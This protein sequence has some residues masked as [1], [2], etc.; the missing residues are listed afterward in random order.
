METQLKEKP[1]R[2]NQPRKST[3][4]KIKLVQRRTLTRNPIRMPHNQVTYLKGSSMDSFTLGL[5]P[6]IDFTRNSN[7]LRVSKFSQ[8]LPKHPL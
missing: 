3:I 4:Q 1:L 5:L 2:G 7:N 6:K 8:Y